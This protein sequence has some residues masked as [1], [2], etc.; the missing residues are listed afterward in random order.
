MMRRVRSDYW[1]MVTGLSIAFFLLFFI[2]PVS[3]VFVNSV[4]DVKTGTFSL[5]AF[6][7]FFSKQ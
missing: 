5:D 4:Y 2:Y 1:A 3:R 6:R 7:K